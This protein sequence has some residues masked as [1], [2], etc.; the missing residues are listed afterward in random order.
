M[1]WINHLKR[2]IILLN[3]VG[4]ALLAGC[5]S[6]DIVPPTI[7]STTPVDGAVDVDQDAAITITFS[8]A[9]NPAFVNTSSFILASGAGAVAGAVTFTPVNTPLPPPPRPPAA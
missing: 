4:A 2:A 1:S 6:V 7:V 3:V 8:E 9:L 5:L